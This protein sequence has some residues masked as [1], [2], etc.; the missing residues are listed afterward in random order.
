MC[1]PNPE[2]WHTQYLDYDITDFYN[3][4]TTLTS[5]PDDQGVQIPFEGDEP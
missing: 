1:D 5:L 3:P 2:M 4:T